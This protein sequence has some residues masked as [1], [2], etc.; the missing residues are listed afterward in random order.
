MFEQV[1]GLAQMLRRRNYW[2]Y[3]VTRFNERVFHPPACPPPTM[4]SREGSVIVAFFV[5]VSHI[6]YELHGLDGLVSFSPLR[7]ARSPT[8]P[9]ISDEPDE[10]PRSTD[11]PEEFSN[12][13][14]QAVPPPAINESCQKY[15][16]LADSLLALIL[17]SCL[18]GLCVSKPV[19]DR[20][21]CPPAFY[22]PK[23]FNIDPHQ[24]FVQDA[25]ASVNICVFWFL[26]NRAHRY[27]SEIIDKHHRA[28]HP[29]RHQR[30]VKIFFS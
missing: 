10:G 6:I 20:K 24:I 3:V 17:F 5:I 25:H 15:S 18:G 7:L 27:L 29:R 8:S 2:V 21:C 22:P 30:L 11:E 14:V 13:K 9:R 16:F 28:L 19:T 12:E 26:S 4:F 23:I 1:F